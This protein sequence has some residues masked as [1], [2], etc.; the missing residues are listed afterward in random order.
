MVGFHEL[1]QTMQNIPRVVKRKGSSG[2]EEREA[3]V[4]DEGNNTVNKAEGGIKSDGNVGV[5]VSSQSGGGKK[6]KKSKR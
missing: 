5:T 3:M 4:I 2:E 1:G 6:K